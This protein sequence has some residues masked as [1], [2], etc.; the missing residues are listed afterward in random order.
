MNARPDIY[1]TI[2]LFVLSRMM[3]TGAFFRLAMIAVAPLM[4]FVAWLFVGFYQTEADIAQSRI[5]SGEIRQ[6]FQTERRDIFPE[7]N[8]RP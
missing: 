6:S 5:E 3:S 7:L 8:K 2:A 4:V 1:S